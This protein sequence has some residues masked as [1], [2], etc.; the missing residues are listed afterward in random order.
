MIWII[1]GSVL[2]AKEIL[3]H[4]HH[5]DSWFDKFLDVMVL[6]VLSGGFFGLLVSALFS[7]VGYF[8]FPTRDV[9]LV[10]KPI[11]SLADNNG[12]SGHFA[13]G[14]GHIDSDL[15]FYYVT[16]EFDG[17]KTIEK[18]KR[19]NTRIVETDETS[20]SVKI[21][22][23]RY[24]HTALNLIGFDFNFINDKTMLTVPKNTIIMDYSVDLR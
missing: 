7:A 4:I 14:T 16:E 24:K 20:P 19:E 10:E 1:L 15:C 6:G 11:Y 23:K 9:V 13:L 8:V 3:R 12:G 17:S 5:S 22:G 18:A 21:T 2:Q